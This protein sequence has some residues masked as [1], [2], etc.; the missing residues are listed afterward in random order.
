[1]LMLTVLKHQ[2]VSDV[3]TVEDDDLVCAGVA[4]DLDAAGSMQR[5]E[6]TCAWTTHLH[7]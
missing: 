5:A 7:I 2:H 6:R 3:L 4:S 1:M